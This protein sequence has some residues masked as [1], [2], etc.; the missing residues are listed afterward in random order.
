MTVNETIHFVYLGEKLPKYAQS[1]LRLAIQHSG[2]DIHLVGNQ[3]L[4][5]D[6]ANINVQ[7]TPIEE[8]YDSSKFDIAKKFISSDANFRSGFWL[9][10]MERF[11]VLEQ[12]MA[13][14]NHEEI[15]HAELD[16]LLFGIN[17]LIS[18][19][20]KLKLNRILYPFH[21]KQSALASVIYIQGKSNIE[22]LTDFGCSG[23]PFKNEMSLLAQWALA[24]PDKASALSTLATEI[25]TS[26]SIL[27][28]GVPIASIEYMGGVVDAAQLGQWI[29]GI[30]PRNVP[31]LKVPRNHFVDPPSDGLL[32]RPELELTKFE[33]DQSRNI[34]HVTLNGQKFRIYN[35]HLHSKCHPTLLREKHN[36][37]SL[38]SKS[39]QEHSIT[40]SGMRRSQFRHYLSELIKIILFD[41]KKLFRLVKTRFNFKFQIR[42]SSYPFIS[43]DTFRAISQHKWEA[44]NKNLRVESIAAGDIVFCESELLKEL[45][46]KVLKH[47]KVPIV[48]LLGNSD[49]NF[50]FSDSEWI[51]ENIDGIVFAQNLV[52]VRSGIHVLPIGLENA[53]RSNHG[54]ISI[55]NVQQS[56]Y[57]KKYKIMWGFTVGTNPEVRTEAM[58]DLG[59][60]EIATQIQAKSA[61]QH[62][63]LLKE[64]AFVASPPGNGLDTHRMWEAMYF[65]CVPIVLRSHLTE[66][67]ESMGMPVWIVDSYAELRQFTDS[68]IE[69]K[70]ESFKSRFENTAIWADYWLREIGNASKSLCSN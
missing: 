34:L 60:V 21:S 51:R 67:L 43:G 50:T 32:T 10:S 14:K 39:N 57:A 13:F 40:I 36:L 61:K 65:K 70:Y 29:A 49:F 63:E 56:R 62:Q 33:F 27:P 48:L 37:T 26:T 3:E 47:V 8:F 59:K 17:Q 7:F 45:H 31:I 11:Y 19:L 25:H 2:C 54:K 38:I 28:D 18:N 53:W 9:K 41:P 5:K 15:F 58:L 30:D 1:S 20:R 42:Q 52:D 23:I 44:N 6:L 68:E 12:F 66:V 55:K 22:S 16:Q 4:R 35:L 46:D 64:Y 69:E 24:N